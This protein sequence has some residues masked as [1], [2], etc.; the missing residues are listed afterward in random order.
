MASKLANLINMDP[1][2]HHRFLSHYL[3]L[4]IGLMF[5][6]TATLELAA[7]PYLSLLNG[8]CCLYIRACKKSLRVKFSDSIDKIVEVLQ[9]KSISSS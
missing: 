6:H 5:S 3:C 1:R 7:H 8:R 4:G 2:S 9:L